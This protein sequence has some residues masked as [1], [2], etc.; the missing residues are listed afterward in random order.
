[1]TPTALIVVHFPASTPIAANH[2]PAAGS[3]ITSFVPSESKERTGGGSRRLDIPMILDRAMVDRHGVPLRFERPRKLR[4]APEALI[5]PCGF[6]APVGTRSHGL[7]TPAPVARF[8]VFP[9]LSRP[10]TSETKE[11]RR[12]HRHV[13]SFSSEQSEQRV[14]PWLTTRRPLQAVSRLFSR[15][16]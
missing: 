12:G 15:V 2:R 6:G 9:D 1:M 11:G 4:H 14:A 10:G 16:R 7:L 3:Q 5:R 13:G 8:R